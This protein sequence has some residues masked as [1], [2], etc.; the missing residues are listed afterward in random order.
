M[1]AEL[2]LDTPV[3]RA[4][5]GGQASPDTREILAS[6]ENPLARK[7]AGSVDSTA[8]PPTMG[9]DEMAPMRR[10]ANPLARTVQLNGLAQVVGLA[11]GAPEFQRR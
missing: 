2:V 9:D 8:V 11:I 1:S 6:G 4:F 10:A 5:L 3:V 7:L